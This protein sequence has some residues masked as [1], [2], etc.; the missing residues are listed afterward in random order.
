MRPFACLVQVVY[1]DGAK[2]FMEQTS[3]HPPVNVDARP[4]HRFASPPLAASTRGTALFLEFLEDPDRRGA[5]LIVGPW[6]RLCQPPLACP[7]GGR[8]GSQTVPEI[9]R[10]PSLDSPAVDALRVFSLLG[11]SLRCRHPSKSACACLHR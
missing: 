2:L 3:H 1:S 8:D 10:G 11:R 5:A 4:P 7:R 9:C 6:A